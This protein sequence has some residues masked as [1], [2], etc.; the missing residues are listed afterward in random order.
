MKQLD[1]LRF[2]RDEEAHDADVN[3]RHFIQ[4]EH[5]LRAVLSELGP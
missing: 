1:A 3:Q 4:V 5:E 2:T